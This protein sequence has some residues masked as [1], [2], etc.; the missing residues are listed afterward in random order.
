MGFIM[1]AEKN[2]YICSQEALNLQLQSDLIPERINFLYT[3]QWPHVTLYILQLGFLEIYFLVP[4][5]M[6][7]LQRI[8]KNMWRTKA[9]KVKNA[10]KGWR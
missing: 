3:S 1:N 8:T 6:E 10:A 7:N 2:I 5:A 4:L 9:S